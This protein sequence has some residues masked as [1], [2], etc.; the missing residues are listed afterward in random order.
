[1]PTSLQLKVATLLGYILV[2]TAILVKLS[3]DAAPSAMLMAA[4]GFG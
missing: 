2:A 3:E 4:G 1:M